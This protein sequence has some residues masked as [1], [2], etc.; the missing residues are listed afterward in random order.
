MQVTRMANKQ[1]GWIGIMFI[2]ILLGSCGKEVKTPAAFRVLSAERTGLKFANTLT[3]TDSFN[4]FKYMYFYNGAGVGAGDFNNDGL[5]DLF[6][7]SNQGRNA[8]Y[9]NQGGLKFKEVT[10][11]SGIP[12]DHAWSTGV[13]IVDINND[14]LLDI[15]VS[16]VGHYMVLNSKN[17]FLICQGVGKDGTPIYKDQA[18][19][20]G[21]DFSGFGTQAAFL[22]YDLDGDLDVFLLSHSIHESGNFSPRSN[23]ISGSLAP[24]GNRFYRNDKGRFTDVTKETHI[25]S[26][27][28]GYGLGIAVSDINL[29]GY[30]DVYVGN[31]FHENDYLYI[32]QRNGS[33]SDVSDSVLMHTSRYT[34]GVDIADASN[35]G[36]PDILT[37]D[38]LPFDAQ[39][40]KRSPGEDS[41][42]IFNLKLSYGYSHQYSRNA[43]QYNRG[44]NDFSEIGMYAGVGA[45]DWSWSPLLMDFDNDRYKDIFISNGIPKRLN[46]IDYI[47]YIS[48]QSLQK[49][50][51]DNNI[52]ERDKT[53]IDRFPHIKIP[54][55]FYSNKGSMRFSE[56]GPAIE[57]DKETYSNGAVYADFDND[58][59][60]DVVVNNIDESALVYENLSNGDSSRR[61]YASLRL[62]GAS[63]NVNALGA[64]VIVYSGDSLEMYEKSPVRGFLSSANTPVH[65]GL[66]GTPV[67]SVVVVWPDNTRQLVREAIKNRTVTIAYRKGLPAFDYRSLT[68]IRKKQKV[69]VSNIAKDLGV[70][71]I[72]QENTFPE[73][74]R[75][76]L[77]PHMVSTEGPALA[78]ADI[79]GDGREDLFF[80]AAKSKKSEVYIQQSSGGFQKLAQPALD[81]D[82]V[83]EDV[84]ALFADVNGDRRADLVVASGGNEYYGRDEH[85]LPR[86]YINDGK[87]TFYRK[88][89]AIKDLYQTTGCLA[90][91]DFNGDGFIDLFVG[92][93]AVPWE[94]GKL[95]YSA[96]LMNDGKGNLSDVTKRFSEELAK[97]GFVTDAFWED[98][99][100]DQRKDLV[101]CSEWGTIDIY[102][103]KAAGFKKKVACARRG[104]WNV[105]FPADINKDGKIDIV[106]GNLGLNTRL[107]ASPRHPVR[108]Y[109]NDFD[110][111][112][113]KE[114]VVTYY[115]NDKE[116]VFASKAEI[117]RQL[118]AMRKKY[119]YA[120]DFANASLEELFSREKLESSAVYV[121]DYFSSSMLIN[122]GNAAFDIKELPWQAQ[123]T[124]IRDGVELD[125]N[126]DGFKDVLLVGNYYG[127][128]V[129]MGRSDAGFSSLLVNNRKGAYLFNELGGKPIKGEARKIRKLFVGDRECFVIAR[130]SDSA[131]VI[132]LKQD[133]SRGHITGQ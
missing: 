94:Y 51:R 111:N 16:R 79:D 42:D 30:P 101:V 36:L 102:F 83:Y 108:M 54:N 41:Y 53:L 37:V 1:A 64:K 87:G 114:Q 80:G 60:L 66:E 90:A 18:A 84:D 28:I 56:L 76:A 19:E 97:A 35:D 59:D 116:T 46:D 130:N 52:D 9:L 29:D 100:G 78:I 65:V 104:W 70:H 85:L 38:M 92:G 17:Q 88:K 77:M 132:E 55:K 57:N 106:A 95:P 74:D 4:L 43:L 96:L 89:D 2:S 6:F 107:K 113:K 62:Q 7:A 128:S 93:R 72:H 8:L 99:D 109:Y 33:F 75:E 120:R 124:P 133:S 117:E 5:T 91:A 40:L 81:A 131:M 11:Q 71:F 69:F 24:T 50:I 86:V 25:N 3:S 61:A 49:Q 67:D 14:G 31:D 13:S 105:I 47:N 123:L 121:A 32:N 118:P 82:S 12:D 15:Y 27:P 110:D 112:G 45:T 73:F 122:K 10:A 103:N 21:L 58:G 68:D 98:M 22:D 34:M 23:F 125:V 20:L 44:S 126:R 127:Y 63:M 119:L 115:I 26:T 48:D 129:E 39:I